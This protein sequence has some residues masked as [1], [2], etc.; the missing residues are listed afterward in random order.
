MILHNGGDA[1]FVVKR[2]DRI[3]QLVVAPVVGVKWD[4]VEDREALGE[5][6]R[7]DGGFGH[8]GRD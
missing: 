5:T 6:R 2:G 8:S 7:A 3:A 1:D 4:E